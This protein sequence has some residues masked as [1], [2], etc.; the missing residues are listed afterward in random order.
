MNPIT[1]TV[2]NTRKYLLAAGAVALLAIGALSLSALFAH[3]A[4]GPVVTNVTTN[5]SN[6][7]V[8]SAA[9]GST[10]T[11][12]ASVASTTSSTV[13]TGTVTFSSYQNLACTGTPTVQ[14]G[15]ALTNGMASSSAIVIPATGLSYIVNYNGD[16]NNVPSVSGCTTVAPT[17]AS[18]SVSTGLSSNNVTVGSSITAN[19]TLSGVTAAATGT[20]AYNFYTNNA[21]TSATTSPAS[22]VVASGNVPTSNAVTFNTPGTYYVRAVYSGDQYN[23]A[24]TSS[25]GSSVLTV[26]AVAPTTGTITVDE[27]TSPA[28]SSTNFQ[29]NTTGSGYGNFSLTDTAAPNVQTLQPGTYTITQPTVAGWNLTSAICSV[30]GSTGGTYAPGSTLTLTAG[31]S[32]VCTF[33]DTAVNTVPPTTGPGTISG[34]FFNDLNKDDLKNNAEAG[35]SG[36][37][38][39]LHKGSGYN[40][41]IVATATT[42]ANGNYSFANLVNGTYFVEEQE[43]AGWNQ[44]TDDT[45]VVLAS[46]SLSAIV[47]FANVQSATSTGSGN[48]HDGKGKHTHKGKDVKDHKNDNHGKGGKDDDSVTNHNWFG[49]LMSAAAKLKHFNH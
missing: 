12:G 36:W 22:V 43:K 8:T 11:L 49:K 44:T 9:I 35:L 16:A 28:A 18:V 32:I 20:V 1:S 31:G 45:K 46:T 5:A 33:T 17:S 47:N 15:V 29:F 41:P 39:W 25:C 42:D 6:A 23:A 10:V 30:N 2:P 19:A 24:A 26:N 4:A 13:P 3:A 40:A 37:T 34:T 14:S 38:V 27:V 48:H 7:V 21:C